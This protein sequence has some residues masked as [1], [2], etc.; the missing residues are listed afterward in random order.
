LKRKYQDCLFEI[1]TL[2]TMNSASSGLSNSNFLAMSAN[3]ILEYAREIV[4]KKLSVQINKNC[5]IIELKVYKYIFSF[6]LNEVFVAARKHK[7]KQNWFYFVLSRL[8]SPKQSRKKIKQVL[9]FFFTI[10]FIAQ[11]KT[12]NKI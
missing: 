8:P 4:L 6:G 7:T 1:I 2:A 10:G 3:V 11:V 9:N 12:L 5:P